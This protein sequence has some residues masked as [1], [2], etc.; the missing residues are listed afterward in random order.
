MD[1]ISAEPEPIDLSRLTSEINEE[2]RRRR[3]A[4]DF[5]P[6]LERE[7]DS[8][9]ARYAPATTGGD[10]DEVVERAERTS[11]V[12]ADVPTAS[13]QRVLGYVKR[14][15]RP[16]MAWYMRF[17]AQQVTAFAGAIT[18]SVRLLGRRVDTLES[19]TVRAAQ[20]SLAEINERRAG[21]DLSAWLDV[22]SDALAGVTGRVLHAECGDGALVARLVADGRDAY[23]VEPVEALA[24]ASARAGL[25]ARADDVLAH[26]R[27]VPDGALAAVVLSG[28]V[29]YLP[30]GA[31][32]EVADLLAAKLEPRGAVVV[33]SASP[34]AWDRARD[35]VV[36]D[37]A[38]GRP[39]HPETWCHLLVA[40]GFTEPIVRR[41]PGDETRE[42]LAPVPP[43]T[44]GAD[45]INANVERLNRLLFEPAGYV[46]SSHLL[47]RS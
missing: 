4:G 45:V 9:F 1:P 40:R 13:N 43:E 34:G 26:L 7:L 15:L 6:G 10:F 36:A 30:L 38:P 47:D 12:H 37:L 25:D 28:V 44:P 39:L 31:L 29:D 46:V 32:L 23:G 5:P 42:R 22:V 33:V 24:M 8:L 16:L 35:P 3:A 27:A 20:R 21:P 19:V 18:R 14:L 41:R 2:V 17:V 11:F